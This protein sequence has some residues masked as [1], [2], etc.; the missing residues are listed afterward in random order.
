MKRL[1]SLIHE[2]N[3]LKKMR[4]S[5]IEKDLLSFLLDQKLVVIKGN[6]VKLSSEG[7]KVIMR[8]P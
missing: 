3:Y 1:Y 8:F 2:I 5:E 7:I 6:Y 4:K